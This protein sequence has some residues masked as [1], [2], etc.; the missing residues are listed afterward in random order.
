MG[1]READ[2][3]DVLERLEASGIAVSIA[4]GWAVDALL[5]RVTREHGD[6]DLA[7]DA[8]D[9]ERAVAGLGDIG[10]AVETDERPARLALGDGTRSVDLHPVEWHATGTGRQ[11]GLAGEP[12]IYPPGSTEAVGRIGPRTVRCLTPALLLDFHL[13]YEPRAIDRE[14]MAALAERFGLAL[15]P[16]YGDRT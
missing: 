16:P 15:P 14:D 13:G 9:V 8:G 11:A 10:L 2:V 4:G 1:M 12:Y 3:L 6:L 7:I 5:G